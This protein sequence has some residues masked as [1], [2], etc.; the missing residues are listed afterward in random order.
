MHLKTKSDR[1]GQG[2]GENEDGHD[3]PVAGK[4]ADNE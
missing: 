1:P 3:E 2:D 4:A